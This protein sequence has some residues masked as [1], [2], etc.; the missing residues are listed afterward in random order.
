MPYNPLDRAKEIFTDLKQH[1]YETEA[2][3]LEIHKAIMRQT[4]IIK[5]GT[6]GSAMGA[7]AKLGWIREKSQGV[8]EILYW[9]EVEE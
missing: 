6:L 4:N 1:G 5:S 9:K 3:T 2:M 8:W 7:F